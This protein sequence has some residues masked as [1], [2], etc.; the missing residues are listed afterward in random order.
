MM[1]KMT[2]FCLICIVLLACEGPGK[3]KAKQTTP[4]SAQTAQTNQ[5]T[6]E[7]V[8]AAQ[9]NQTTPE[10]VPATQ[11]NQSNSLRGSDLRDTQLGKDLEKACRLGDF[12][13]V[14]TLVP[15]LPDI[16]AI[17]SI[18]GSTALHIASD[19]GRLDIVKYLVEQ[20]AN[21]N[22]RDWFPKTPLHW[23]CERSR[24]EI[25]E[26]LVANGADVNAVCDNNGRTPLHYACQRGKLEIVKCLVTHGANLDVKDKQFGRT[27]LEDASCNWRNDVVSYLQTVKR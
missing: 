15:Q 14:K 12:D 17:I 25:V 22:A 21:V 23:A 20:G 7:S 11:T 8:P 10:S 13:T 19:C 2:K 4:E 18:L 6:S 26:F 1:A 9:T 24:L 16:N 27:P 3:N 5:T